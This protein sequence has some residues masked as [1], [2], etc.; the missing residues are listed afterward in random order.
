MKVRELVAK[1]LDIPDPDLEIYV[2]NFGHHGANHSLDDVVVERHAS[3][4]DGPYIVV[5]R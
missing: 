5:L 4:P 1:L 2:E 3:E